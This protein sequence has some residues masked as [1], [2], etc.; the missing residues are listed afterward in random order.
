MDCAQWK[1]K[2]EW[3]KIHIST[4]RGAFVNHSLI[5]LWN[6]SWF[7]CWP[8]IDIQGWICRPHPCMYGLLN[9]VWMA[10][11][12]KA[13]NS[14]QCLNHGDMYTQILSIDKCAFFVQIILLWCYLYDRTTGYRYTEWVKIEKLGK[15]PSKETLF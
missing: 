8:H 4:F 1:K 11:G 7:I 9:K 5:Y 12:T 15:L 6:T 14:P 13:L 2:F 10:I 3:R